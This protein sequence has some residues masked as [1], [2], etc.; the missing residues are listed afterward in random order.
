MKPT[1]KTLA[2]IALAALS[3][4]PASAR[5][6]TR[7]LT[8]NLADD[9]LLINADII[10]DDLRLKSNHQAFITPV[11]SVPA[12]S[13]ASATD[14]TK[15]TAVKP[16]TLPSILV[17]GRNMHIS[18]ERGVLRNFPAI[19]EHEIAM[20][21]ERK[22]GRKQSIP[23]ASRIPAQDWMREQ[24][25][26]V[27]FMCD[28]CGC[29]VE[30]GSVVADQALLLQTPVE[31]TTNFINTMIIVPE[32]DVPNVMIHAGKARIQF[33]V[34][35]TGLHINPYVCKNGQYID[36]RD[37]L[38][39]IDD[40][41]KYALS[42]PNVELTGIDICGYASPESPYLHNEELA[43]GRSKVLAEYLADRYN[44]P[45]ESVTYSAVVENWGEF[46]DMVLESREITERQR[47]QLLDLI[48]APA[49]TPEDY[50]RKEWTLKTDPR[51][52]QLYRSMILP[53][54]FPKLRA[55]TFVL[56]TQLRE[57]DDAK[58]AEV[59]RKTPEKMSL[60]Q[61][62]R[63][64]KAYPADSDEFNDVMLAAL[65][66]YPKDPT[67]ITNAAIAATAREEYSRAKKLL[68]S[69][70]QTSAVYN[71]RA[72]IAEAEGNF[73]EAANC[74]E[75][76]GDNENALRTKALIKE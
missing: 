68:A 53:Q 62:C 22:N 65:K 17:S 37:Q 69:V 40:S 28:T 18:Y 71:L 3:I 54:W 15:R 56:K 72:L 36:N 24:G 31:N 59:F 41:V 63:V 10:L 19:K 20:E 75:L 9:F 2:A 48:D 29:G 27:Q 6:T 11:V 64:A 51:F 33:E 12:D 61:L 8:I 34:D 39:I 16:I 23:Y 58:L 25:V 66:Y 35:R 13:A 5:I 26:R 57:M 44:L 1:F 21:I 46:R 4:F 55:T 47:Q 43:T 50:D 32:I 42:D 60:A 30:L 45:Y 73:E 14:N 7:D 74:Y 76:A 67:A 52:A 38:K 70:P 49:Y